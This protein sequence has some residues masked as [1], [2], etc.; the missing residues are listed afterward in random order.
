MISQE[1]K[2]RLEEARKKRENASDI[3]LSYFSGLVAGF[4]SALDVAL[5]GEAE[6]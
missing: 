3:E 1:I 5:L 6:K 4:R 2:R